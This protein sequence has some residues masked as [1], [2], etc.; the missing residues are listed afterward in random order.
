MAVIQVGID[1]CSAC[2]ATS[3]SSLR[4]RAT[5]T[6]SRA[7][8]LALARRADDIEFMAFKGAVQFALL[9]MRASFCRERAIL[10]VVDDPCGAASGRHHRMLREQRKLFWRRVC[11][12]RRWQS[13]LRR[14][15]RLH[16]CE[17][18]D[19]R[20]APEKTVFFLCSVG[21]RRHSTRATARARQ[22]GRCGQV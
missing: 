16:R 10:F 6:R 21:R 9:R 5:N 12:G 8:T 1:A 15:R 22:C 13:A 18:L 19:T 17:Q 7:Q 14:I 20:H 4:S 2:C 3:V 11:H